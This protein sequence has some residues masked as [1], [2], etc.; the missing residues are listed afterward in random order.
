MWGNNAV[1]MKY[2]CAD[3]RRNDVAIVERRALLARVYSSLPEYASPVFWPTLENE[4][5][6]LEILVRILRCRIPGSDSRG[7][8]RLIE[9]IIS[10]TRLSNEYWAQGVLEN[11]ALLVD[12][13]YALL[14]DLCADLYERVIRA[15]TDPGRAF[16][17]E[18]FLHALRF[19]RRH[20]CHT[21]MRREGLWLDPGSRRGSRVPRMLMARLDQPVSREEDELLLLDIEDER[22]QKNMQAV[23][24][25]DLLRLVLALPE[26]LKLVLLLVFWED[27]TEKNTAQIL[28][29]TDR[30][31]R[32]RLRRALRL[33][34][35]R[36]Q[37]EAMCS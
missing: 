25:S 20:V 24:E 30:T 13:R 6:P 26:R 3:G 2:V 11:K 32:N 1:G 5:I 29:V 12:E 18:N 15:L 27:R 16:W 17:E 34:Q 4:K 10:R 37:S 14:C 23:E 22:A 7:R 31:V 28:G 21:F 9:I 8:N 33:L 36:L 35:N 19:E